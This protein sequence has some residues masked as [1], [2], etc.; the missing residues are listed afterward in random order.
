MN[1]TLVAVLGA[2]ALLLAGCGTDHEGLQPAVTNTSAAA[3]T[4]VK[5]LTSDEKFV[6]RLQANGLF[7]APDKVQLLTPAASGYCDQ[8]P[9]L[10]VPES[11]KFDQ[12]VTTSMDIGRIQGIDLFEDRATTERFVRASIESYCPQLGGILPRA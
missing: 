1:K 8:V 11:Q 10:N 5:I 9:V 6:L 12:L 2:G 3:P 7:P 4:S